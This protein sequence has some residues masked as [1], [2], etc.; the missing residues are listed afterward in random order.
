MS[1]FINKIVS[2]YNSYIKRNDVS[3][4][5]SE[6]DDILEKLDKMKQSGYTFPK[7]P[8]LFSPFIC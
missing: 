5:T 7:R 6:F 3:E 2:K 8:S 1:T 4:E